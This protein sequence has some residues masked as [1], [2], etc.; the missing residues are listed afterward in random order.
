M[1]ISI[2]YSLLHV[3]EILQ[4]QGMTHGSG[5]TPGPILSDVRV[6]GTASGYPERAVTEGSALTSPSTFC[7]SFALRAGPLYSCYNVALSAPSLTLHISLSH[8]LLTNF[9]LSCIFVFLLL[10][11]EVELLEYLS[12][13][14]C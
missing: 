10:S 8:F 3:H 6:Q 12:N 11:L 9:V 4:S 2:L 5:Q 1:A 13:F 14:H 7:A